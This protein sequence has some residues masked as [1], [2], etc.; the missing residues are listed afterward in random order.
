VKRAYK[1]EGGAT[2]PEL[3]ADHVKHDV[4]DGFVEALHLQNRL[5]LRL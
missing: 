2:V 1:E 3:V 4:S 5:P